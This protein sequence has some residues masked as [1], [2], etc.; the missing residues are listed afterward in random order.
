MV[1]AVKVPVWNKNRTK[2][3]KY[4]KDRCPFQ[5]TKFSKGSIYTNKKVTTA[6]ISIH[7]MFTI[8]GEFNKVRVLGFPNPF[9]SSRWS[10]W[11]KCDSSCLSWKDSALEFWAASSLI[12]YAPDKIIS[13]V[14]SQARDKRR[15]KKSTNSYCFLHIFPAE[16]TTTS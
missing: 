15:M 12:V 16:I 1:I 6:V 13:A 4:S 9:R 11:H 3:F 5:H 7:L 14:S 8:F 2:S 10:A